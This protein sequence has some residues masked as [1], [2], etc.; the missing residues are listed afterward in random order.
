MGTR[1]IFCLLLGLMMLSSCSSLKGLPNSQKE[2]DLQMMSYNIR[3]AEEEKGDI[4]WSKRKDLVLRQ[5]KEVPVDIYMFQEPLNNQVDDI[6]ESLTNY[7]FVGEPRIDILKGGGYNAIFYN[8]DKFKLLESN[9]FWLSET[10]NVESKGWDANQARIATYA[11]LKDKST[12]KKFFVFNLHL[13]RVGNTA[14][15]E[16]LKLIQ[17]KLEEI[18]KK[19]YP[20]IIGGDFNSKETTEPIAYFDNYFKDSKKV[21]QQ[22]A[23]GPKGTFNYFNSRL[24]HRFRIDYIYVSQEIEVKSYQV[25][26]YQYEGRYPSDHYPVYV[27]IMI[28]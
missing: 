20:V 21:S 1:F 16:S 25:L 9:T 8:Q 6:K 3:Y 4:S 24:S 11:L 17:K 27:E 18:N 2:V 22:E 28:P 19:Q 26:D 12:R 7:G 14:K 10:P 15:L 5:I 23:L 13:D